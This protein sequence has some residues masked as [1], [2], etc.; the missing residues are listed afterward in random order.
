[1]IQLKLALVIFIIFPAIHMRGVMR[2]I[3]TYL[4]VCGYQK[5]EQR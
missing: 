4:N 1:M 3:A 5:D 2:S